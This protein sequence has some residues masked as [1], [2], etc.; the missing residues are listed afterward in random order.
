M[1]TEKRIKGIIIALATIL[2]LSGGVWMVSTNAYASPA[3]SENA[4]SSQSKYRN[5][6]CSVMEHSQRYCQCSGFDA[7]NWDA[8]R[9]R[10]CGHKAVKHTR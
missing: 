4:D 5:K 10:K 1:K 3:D 8:S 9:C 7:Q 6:K 2:C